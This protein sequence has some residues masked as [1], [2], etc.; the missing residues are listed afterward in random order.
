M[1]GSALNIGRISQ[2]F[3]FVLET[4]HF[5]GFQAKLIKKLSAIVA[6]GLLGTPSLTAVSR[7]LAARRVAGAVPVYVPTVG[8]LH[9]GDTT[10]EPVLSWSGGCSSA[11]VHRLL[12]QVH[13]L[14]LISVTMYWC[15]AGLATSHCN[16]KLRLVAKTKQLTFLWPWSCV[17]WWKAKLERRELR[18]GLARSVGLLDTGSSNEIPGSVIQSNGL[19]LL[20]GCEVSPDV[21]SYK[22][23]STGFD[24]NYVTPSFQLLPDLRSAG[25]KI[26][27]LSCFVFSL[28]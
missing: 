20:P 11:V 8:R 2:E 12:S 18:D 22:Y 21:A 10:Q 16:K 17:C 9:T 7:A 4:F 14:L 6:E 13:C 19:T 27:K 28:H 1:A 25:H 24:C 23:V 3:V 26:E 15:T 5:T